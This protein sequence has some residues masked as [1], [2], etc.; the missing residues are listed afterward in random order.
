MRKTAFALFLLL[1][2]AAAARAQEKKTWEF[3][4][5]GWTDVPSA[6]SATSRPADEPVLDRAEQLLYQNDPK[7]ARHMLLDWEKVNKTN[8]SR[9]RC[10]YLLADAFYRADERIK[11]FYYCDELMDEYPESNLYQAAL[12]RQYQIADEYLAGHKRTFLF[13][14]ILDA[15]DDAVQ[16]MYRIQQRAPGSPLAER[17]LL[18]TA[19]YYFS[20]RDYDLSADAYNSYA[21]SYPHSPE[22]PRVKLRAAFSSLAQ[23]RGVRFDATNIIDARAQLV[24]IQHTYPDLAAEE[25]V[26]SVIEQIDSAFAKKILETAQYYERTHE[27]RAAVYNYRFLAATYPL[28]PEAAVARTRLTRMPP[29]ALAEPPP[30]PAS[31]YAPT[32]VLPATQPS[33]SLN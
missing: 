23:F 4:N 1:L 11:S 7:A 22:L 33:A 29:A 15:T 8:P 16:M 5:G 24:D 10:I 25:N 21:R 26:A 27:P 32:N 13:F 31:G 20:D 30:A 19:D 2:T 12:A 28:A 14:P 17:A 3:R 6:A 18:R 9:D